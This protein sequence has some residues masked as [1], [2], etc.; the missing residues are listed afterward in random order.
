MRR[1][2]MILAHILLPG[3]IDLG[4]TRRIAVSTR[5]NRIKIQT[6]VS[7]ARRTAVSSSNSWVPWGPMCIPPAQHVMLL[8]C[9]FPRCQFNPINPINDNGMLL[10]NGNFS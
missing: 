3:P 4:P 6:Y 5:T 9:G 8:D 10:A 2:D 1:D 7:N